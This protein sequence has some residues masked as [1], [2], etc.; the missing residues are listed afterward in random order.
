MQKKYVFFETQRKF[1]KQQISCE[2]KLQVHVQQMMHSPSIFAGTCLLQLTRSSHQ[3]SLTLMHPLQLALKQGGGAEVG[4]K[5]GLRLGL[6]VGL[7][8]GPTLGTENS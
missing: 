5:V 7:W 1:N 4:A 6:E 8:P 2:V 3:G